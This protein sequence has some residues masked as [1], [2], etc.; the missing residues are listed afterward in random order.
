LWH[1]PKEDINV[2]EKVFTALIQ[3]TWILLLSL[4]L[5]A[6][7]AVVVLVTGS[8]NEAQDGLKLAILLPLPPVCWDYK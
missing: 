1:C 3:L 4:L 6:A 5:L 8:H 7:V 2:P